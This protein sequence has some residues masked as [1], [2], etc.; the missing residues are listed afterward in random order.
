MRWK[1]KSPL[2]APGAGVTSWERPT[3]QTRSPLPCVRHSA[4]AIT[5]L[6]CLSLRQATRPS[7]NPPACTASRSRKIS[8]TEDLRQ[9]HQL[10]IQRHPHIVRGRRGHEEPPDRV[11]WNLH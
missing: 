2:L 4:D 10:E 1:R 8:I 6:T 5:R 11:V 9:N 7:T 3:P